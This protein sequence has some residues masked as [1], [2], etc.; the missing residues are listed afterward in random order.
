MVN[1]LGNKAVCVFFQI[2][3]F[4]SH[5]ANLFLTDILMYE[6]NEGMSFHYARMLCNPVFW[7]ILILQLLEGFACAALN[8][9]A[10]SNDQVVEQ[11][12]ADGKKTLI[13]IAVDY[14]P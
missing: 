7:V 3:C 13:G 10:K 5:A 4:I 9:C 2:I 12:Y 8:S 1:V 6:V 14:T 11:A